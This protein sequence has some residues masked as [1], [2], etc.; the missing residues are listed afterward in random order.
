MRTKPARAL[1]A[2]GLALVLLFVA[3]VAY[4]PHTD[5]ASYRDDAPAFLKL[6]RVYEDW[7]VDGTRDDYEYTV[8]VD[9]NMHWSR[10]AG[11]ERAGT[12]RFEGIFG[13]LPADHTP[14]DLRGLV[15]ERGFYY[16]LLEL[17]MLT[18]VEWMDLIRFLP[19]LWAAFTAF[20]V[21]AALRPWPG[22]LVA[23]TLVALTP[24]S[25]R[26]LGPGF[27]VP[28]G[29][30]LAFVA[31]GMLLTSEIGRRGRA[32]G[33]L[34]LLT[35]WAFFI[36]LIA[37]FALVLL[38]LATVPF[39][40]RVKSSL[41]LI[42]TAIL[43]VVAMAE[44]FTEGVQTELQ[45]I[46]QLPIDLTIFDQ[47]GTPFLA[48][49]V[50]GCALL[51]LPHEKPAPRV[52][53]ASA[54]A[55]GIAFAFLVTAIGTASGLYAIYDRWHQPFVLFATLPAAFA[56][57]RIAGWLAGHA[58]RLAARRARV[59]A[60]SAPAVAGVVGIALL[61]TATAGGLDGHLD[62]TYY[63]VLDDEE[64]AAFR[65]VAA[66]VN[67]TY[68]VFLAE[69]WSAVILNAMTGKTPHAWLPP[70]APPVNG[71]DWR[72]FLAGESN[73]GAW[74]VERDISL[75]VHR[76]DVAAAYEPKA[77]NVALLE[78][79]YAKELARLRAE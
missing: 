41:V 71:E 37:G 10:M 31:G 4:L 63:R 18:G 28:I 36:H 6:A 76:G 70:G 62:E 32:T 55:S 43:P 25:A 60:W 23:A 46:G 21:Y 27:L 50:L 78:W 1:E 16:A 29:F 30:G 66:N 2:A 39:E 51:V 26:F 73:D 48:A 77:E 13:G 19:A 3:L 22:A 52:V 75:V 74:L 8:H 56:I 40:K 11:M 59:P 69:P 72:A 5:A 68:D 64:Y 53:L 61:G 42:G 24:T 7:L 54:V 17:K 9:E 35:L 15:H 45:R 65:W 38:L 79:E 44:V 49:W 20:T 58:R 57:V 14:L 47:V 34:L 33:A 12:L 67:D